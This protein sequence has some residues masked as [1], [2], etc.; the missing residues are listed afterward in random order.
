MIRRSTFRVT[1]A[2]FVAMFALMLLGAGGVA[3]VPPAWSISATPIPDTVSPGSPAAFSVTISNTGKLP[4]PALFL[5][6][7][8]SETPLSVTPSKGCKATGPLLCSLGLLGKG[9]SVTVVVVY[10]TPVSAASFDVTFTATR[11]NPFPWLRWWLHR[12]AFAHIDASAS[13]TLNSDPNFVGVYVV[14]KN[15]PIT[16]ASQQQTT[17]YPP[18]NGIG[19]TIKEGGSD[20]C[21]NLAN[22]IGEQVTLNVGG[23]THFASVFKTSL[24]IQAAT[25]PDELQLGD[26]KLCHQYDGQTTGTLLPQCASAT[27]PASGEAACFW[28]SWGEETHRDGES[29]ASEHDADDYDQLFIDVFDYENGAIRGGW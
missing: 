10:P 17:V 25:L 6:D 5:T 29:S 28:P 26:V 22:P 9:K 11:I 3:A 15:V 21:A 24:T 14:D 2:A 4:I 1:T 19:V 27:G 8:R 12:G 13:T 23:G 16:T 18:A 20:S 7:S